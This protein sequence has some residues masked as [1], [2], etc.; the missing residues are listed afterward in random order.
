MSSDD[1]ALNEWAAHILRQEN[2]YCQEVTITKVQSKWL[3]SALTNPNR[4]SIKRSACPGIW[5][6]PDYVRLIRTASWSR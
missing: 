4:H 6:G 5:Q 2:R 1:Q 3:C